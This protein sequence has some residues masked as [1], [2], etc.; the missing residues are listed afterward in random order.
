MTGERTPAGAEA[1]SG[2]ESR[3]AADR[4]GLLAD[5]RA[6]AEARGHPTD[7][8]RLALER[9]DAAIAAREL[10]PT[11]F[12]ERAMADLRAA[13]TA[14]EGQRLGGKSGEASRMILR[15]IVRS[16]GEA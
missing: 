8:A 1:A 16:L 9:L 6:L 10:R 7:N 5:L 11:P 4:G 3:A 12:L 14:S 13:L 2:Q 15:A